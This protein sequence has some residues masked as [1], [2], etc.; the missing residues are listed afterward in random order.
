MGIGKRIKELRE[1]A[2]LTRMNSP[3][4]WG[5]SIAVGNYERECSHPKENVLYRLFEALSCRAYELF[6]DQFDA[7]SAPGQVHLKKV[8]G[9]R[10]PRP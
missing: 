10:Q 8:S 4:G 7:S 5:N 6:A 1:R 9:A 3:S 2:G